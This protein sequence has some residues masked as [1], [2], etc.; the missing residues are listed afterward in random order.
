MKRLLFVAV[1]AGALALMAGHADAVTISF[2]DVP[3]SALIDVSGSPASFT[4]STGPGETMTVNLRGVVL[5]GGEP[6]L[7][8]IGL[9]EPPLGGISDTITLSK[10]VATATEPAGIQIVFR[11]EPFA[12]PIPTC[13]SVDACQPESNPIIRPIF[14]AT[15]GGALNQSLIVTVGAVPEPTTLLLLGSGLLGVGA[16]RYRKSRGR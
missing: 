10:L 15:T 9:T 3:L 13:A 16:V 8:T 7:F 1:I 4:T 6:D 5:A 12:L 14:S 11:S 2:F